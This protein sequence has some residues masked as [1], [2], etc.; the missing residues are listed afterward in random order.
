MVR[1]LVTGS[2]DWYDEGLVREE[3]DRIWDRCL[4]F[5]M[6]TVVHGG[7]PT[8]ADK[9]AAKWVDSTRAY[10]INVTE[11]IFPADWEKH[12]RS[13]GPIRNREMVDSGPE[14]F[15][16]FVRNGSPGAMGTVNLCR[17]DRIPGAVWYVEDDDDVDG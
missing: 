11:E 13:A 14:Y 12:G 10:E 17:Q 16:A 5:E 15:L 4:P 9:Y 6:I 1:V 2:R 7:C 8:G 3:L